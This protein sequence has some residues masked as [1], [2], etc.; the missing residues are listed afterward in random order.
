MRKSC[1]T[2]N[3]HSVSRGHSTTQP[4]PGQIVMRVVEKESILDSR[5]LCLDTAQKDINVC[6][7]SMLICFLKK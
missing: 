2:G 5:S 7:V 6:S 4:S 1:N 3:E